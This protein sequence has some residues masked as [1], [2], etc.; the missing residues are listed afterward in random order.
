MGGEVK[1]YQI[2]VSTE[3]LQ[4]RAVSLEELQHALA[5]ISENTTGGFIDLDGRE[6]LIRP[7]A[8]VSSIADIENSLVGM[9]FGQPVLVKDVAEVRLGA[10]SKRGEAS[11]NAHPS[12][13]LTIQKQPNAS[14]ID[15][16]RQI[17]LEMAAIQKTLP[18][19]VHI[20]GE[21]FKQANFIEASVANVQGALR[22]GI[23]IV[24]AVLF[25][26]LLN[27]RTT[28]ITLVVIPLSLLITAIVFHFLGLGVNTMTLGGLAVAIGELVDDAIVDVENVFRRLKENRRAGSPLSPLKVIYEAFWYSYRCSL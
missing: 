14:T 3:R 6:Y 13:I 21:L 18:Q 9:H 1:Q 23:G 26:F 7:L 28:S 11:I 2:L 25:F 17:D 8:R 10:K 27:L 15:L 12:V 20:E 22:D 19:G 5:E 24:A 16:T 4:K